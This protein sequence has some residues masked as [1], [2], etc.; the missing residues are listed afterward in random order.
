M[1]I[2]KRDSKEIDL[3]FFSSLIG[4]LD[5]NNSKEAK[6]IEE[7]VKDR[8]RPYIHSNILAKNWVDSVGD[9]LQM[10]IEKK[11]PLMLDLYND[12]QNQL[13]DILKKK[14]SG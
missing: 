6:D 14:N 8:I 12:R 2:I 13:N 11:T 7:I 4:D 3:I 9:Q 5:E 1:A 10:K